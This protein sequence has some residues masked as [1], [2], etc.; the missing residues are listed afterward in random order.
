MAFSKTHSFRDDASWL[1]SVLEVV[2]KEGG[3]H[4]QRF[5]QNPTR[6]NYKAWMKGEHIV[7]MEKDHGAFAT[8]N[9]EPEEM[10]MGKMTDEVMKMKM[11]RERLVVR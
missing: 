7:P 2:D 9:K 8:E 3:P 4:C 10:D 1:P 6:Q 11:E 5:L